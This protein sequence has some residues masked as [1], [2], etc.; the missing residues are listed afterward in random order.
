MASRCS[1]IVCHAWYKMTSSLHVILTDWNLIIYGWKCVLSAMKKN[2]ALD[3]DLS[4]R[5][6]HLKV[7]I[8]NAFA[9]HQSKGYTVESFLEFLS[10]WALAKLGQ[11]VTFSKHA[12]RLHLLFGHCALRLWTGWRL[13]KVIQCTRSGF[14][15][16]VARLKLRMTLWLNSFS[17]WELEEWEEFGFQLASC[18][19]K[20]GDGREQMRGLEHWRFNAYMCFM[21]EFSVILFSEIK[22]EN[23]EN[24]KQNQTVW[25][26][27][28]SSWCKL[29]SVVV[30]F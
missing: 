26:K 15:F 28:S 23:G 22:F 12:I 7:G 19:E 1:H 20:H 5:P 11:H 27:K 30:V 9:S 8:H 24:W 17:S 29:I 14:F 10:L 25:S 21:Y 2:V 4:F 18:L 16:I 3:L 13:E 6:L